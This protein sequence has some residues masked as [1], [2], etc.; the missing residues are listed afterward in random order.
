MHEGMT[1][2]NWT[3]NAYPN[4]SGAEREKI[5]LKKEHGKKKI[6]RTVMYY[7]LKDYL[8]SYS[9]ELIKK[10][11]EGNR[12]RRLFARKLDHLLDFEEDSANFEWWNP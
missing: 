10:D 8:K 9:S 4:S 5:F 3:I 2:D 6:Y 11:A 12:M 7:K 1:K